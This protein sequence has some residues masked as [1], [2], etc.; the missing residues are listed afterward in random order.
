MGRQSFHSIEWGQL[1]C[2]ILWEGFLTNQEPTACSLSIGPLA[3][4][5]V[6]D[7]Y[8]LRV[9]AGRGWTGPWQLLQVRYWFM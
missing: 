1:R 9:N 4:V 2:T 8:V 5:G 3:D 7:V 6:L